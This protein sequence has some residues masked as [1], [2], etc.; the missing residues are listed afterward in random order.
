MN[1][2]AVTVHGDQDSQ[3]LPEPARGP[4]TARPAGRQPSHLTCW[5]GGH[6]GTHEDTAQRSG[7]ESKREGSIK[8]GHNTVSSRRGDPPEPPLRFAHPAVVARRSIARPEGPAAP[9]GPRDGGGCA[10]PGPLPG[11]DRCFWGPPAPPPDDRCSSYAEVTIP[12]PPQPTRAPPSSQPPSLTPAPAIVR[13]CCPASHLGPT[14][15]TPMIYVDSY[16]RQASVPE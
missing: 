2:H 8:P 13:T 4:A 10:A 5:P 7:Y 16:L 6:D 11:A 9:R 3:D 15:C 14:T 12:G 1:G